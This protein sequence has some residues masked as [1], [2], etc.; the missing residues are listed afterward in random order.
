MNN[1]K[2]KRVSSLTIIIGC[3][4]FIIPF[5]QILG[6]ILLCIGTYL[7]YMTDR[8]KKQKTIWALPLILCSVLALVLVLVSKWL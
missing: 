7:N 3:I 1:F 4:I 2:S 6:L 5:F 8:T